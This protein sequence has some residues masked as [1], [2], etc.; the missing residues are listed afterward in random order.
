MLVTHT[1]SLAQVS[2]LYLATHHLNQASTG[3]GPGAHRLAFRP[4]VTSASP[5]RRNQPQSTPTASAG[6]KGEGAEDHRCLPPSSLSHS[7]TRAFWEQGMLPNLETVA[8]TWA[9]LDSRR[10]P[11]SQETAYKEEKWNFPVKER[12][13]DS[14]QSPS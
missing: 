10:C 12:T 5:A 3:L 14:N 2:G 7:P 1:H 4:A 11:G 6:L 9:T 13:K 8:L